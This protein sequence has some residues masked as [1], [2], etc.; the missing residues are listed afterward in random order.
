[1]G[2]IN[3]W[4]CAWTAATTRSLDNLSTEVFTLSTRYRRMAPVPGS[5][6]P[7]KRSDSCRELRSESV[8]HHLC[9]AG[10]TRRDEME[11]ASGRGDDGPPAAW[12]KG[13]A[14]QATSGWLL[15]PPQVHKHTAE[16]REP[17]SKLLHHFEGSSEVQMWR[18]HESL[19]ARTKGCGWKFIIG[20]RD[21]AAHLM[22]LSCGGRSSD[23]SWISIYRDAAIM[24][25]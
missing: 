11:N 8:I 25:W 17:L 5:S 12:A 23:S 7:N 9:L 15:T 4:F 3:G 1:M 21:E 18:Q 20:A 6:G 22:I 13:C 16:C 24:C 10:E 2:P 19:L 14:C